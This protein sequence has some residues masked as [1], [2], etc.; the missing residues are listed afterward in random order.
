MFLRL[1]VQWLEK[2]I[3][4]CSSSGIGLSGSKMAELSCSGISF[5]EQY[6]LGN[7]FCSSIMVT[8]CYSNI[9]NSSGM[10]YVQLGSGFIGS[11]L[12]GSLN[13]L[14]ESELVCLDAC[15]LA[16]FTCLIMYDY[17]GKQATEIFCITGVDFWF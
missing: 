8:G 11:R 5:L 13:V 4:S 16:G 6:P 1:G 10:S 7:C 15:K 17:V 14:L 3:S 2:L 9:A 12:V